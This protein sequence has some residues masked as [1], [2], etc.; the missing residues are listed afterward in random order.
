MVSES[1]RLAGRG[2]AEFVQTVKNFIAYLTKNLI[3]YL[4]KELKLPN[5]ASALAAGK[6]RRAHENFLSAPLVPM[7]STTS[8]ISPYS[9]AISAVM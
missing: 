2:G 5:P 8:S 3:A 6:L 7:E 4:T 1:A 9:L